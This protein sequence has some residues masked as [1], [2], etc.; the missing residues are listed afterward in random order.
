MCDTFII[1]CPKRDSNSQ[2]LASK[3]NT[4]TNSVIGAKILAG[5]IGFEPM[6]VGIKIR[7]LNQLG[8]SP[9]KPTWWMRVESNYHR[10]PYEGGTLPL[11]YSSMGCM[12]GFEPTYIGI[13]IRGLDRLTTR[14]IQKHTTS[15]YGRS[16]W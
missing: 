11:C 7:C 13:T 3:T 6:R 8:E 9:I 12:M 5:D 4:Y 10:T 1:W 16:P 2:N 15:L 14:T